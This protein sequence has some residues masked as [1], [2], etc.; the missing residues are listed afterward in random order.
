MQSRQVRILELVIQALQSLVQELDKEPEKPTTTYEAVL[1][2]GDGSGKKF[3]YGSYE[4]VKAGQALMIYEPAQLCA[5]FADRIRARMATTVL[6]SNSRPLHVFDMCV[7]DELK[8]RRSHSI[9]RIVEVHHV[10]APVE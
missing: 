5:D 10:S 7:E 4:S 2:V 3:L 1:G 6:N 8:S 9:S